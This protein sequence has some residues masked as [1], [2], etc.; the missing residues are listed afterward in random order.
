MNG[1][2]VEPAAMC[3]WRM[4][5]TRPVTEISAVSLS[6]SC[7]TLPRPGRAK[8]ATCGNMIRRNS[9]QRGMPIA[10][11][12]SIWPRGTASTAPRITSVE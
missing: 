2:R 4:I 1:W 12:A 10:W 6:V 9:S 3:A 11:A 5:S 7:Q 8:R